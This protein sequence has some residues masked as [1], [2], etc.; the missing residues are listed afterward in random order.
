M[1]AVIHQLVVGLG[2][3]HGDDSVAW[4]VVD[5]LASSRSEWLARKASSA[6][7]LF[8]WLEGVARLI[9]VDGCHGAGPP[10]TITRWRWP[11]VPLAALRGTGSHDVGLAEVLQTATRLGTLPAQVDIIGIEV[12]SCRSGEE[13][14]S[15]AATSVDT[16]VAEL[17]REVNHA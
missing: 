9:I 6:V 1:C 11:A 16:L 5:A 4:Q 17:R 2:S 10:G 8:D 14:S 15:V 7:D 3:P 13:L 12:G